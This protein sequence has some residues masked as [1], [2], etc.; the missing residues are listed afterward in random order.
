M[1]NMSSNERQLAPLDQYVV[2]LFSSEDEVLTWIQAEADRNGLPQISIRPHEGRLLQILMKALV[3]RKVLEIGTLAGYSTVWLA[4]A[5]PVD[6]KLITLEKSSKHAEV[7][8]TSIDR[9]GLDKKVTIWEGNAADLL[10]KA[11]MQAPFD[12]I[13]IDADKTSYVNYLEW[14]AENLRPGGMVTA[15]NAY[16]GGRILAPES[17]DDKA[18][19]QFNETLAHHPR[20]ESTIIGVG[21]ALAVG[22]K[23]S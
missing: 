4:R 14:A 20:F 15:H 23:K 2:D 3:A 19:A 9:A 6:G 17:D 21:D 22:L 5:L 8:R 16:R 7:A 18:I 13:F 12:F 10:E 11:R 1:S